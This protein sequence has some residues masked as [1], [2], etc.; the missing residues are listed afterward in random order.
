MDCPLGNNLLNLKQHGFFQAH[1]CSISHFDF[2]SLLINLASLTVAFAVIYLD[3]TKGFPRVPHPRPASKVSSFGII[4]ALLSRLSSY[5]TQ[6]L[7]VASIDCFTSNPKPV[8][9]GAIQSSAFGPLLFLMHVNDS[10]NSISDK[11]PLL[12]AENMKI[13]QL[14]KHN[15]LN[16]VV[17]ETFADL[18]ALDC[19]CASSLVGFSPEKG[20][21]LTYKFI[22]PKDSIFSEELQ[23]H[24]NPQSL[25]LASLSFS[26]HVAI[27][28]AIPKRNVS[29]IFRTKKL[30][31]CVLCIYKTHSTDL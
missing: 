29:L 10:L 13:T 16:T 23:S 18:S 8:T 2:L 17:R 6:S 14:L 1:F 22:L 11:A 20:E 30:S 28:S 26:G 9:S 7:Q 31:G 27:Q 15:N 21:M 4:D 25:I 19:W 12:F 3:I 24:V 5:L